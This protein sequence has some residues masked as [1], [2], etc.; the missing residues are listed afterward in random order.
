MADVIRG[1]QP[2]EL[3][4]TGFRAGPRA[5]EWFEALFRE[6]YPRI[7]ALVAR[8][9]GDRSQAEEIAA[10]SFSKL[11]ARGV[12]LASRQDVTAWVYRVATNAGLDAIRA[13]TRRRRK[14]EAASR[15]QLRTGEHTGALD[16]LLREERGAQ[17]RTI[18]AELKPRDAEILLLRSSG[19]AYREIA[20][21]LGIA[22]SSVG[23]M[24]ARAEREFE[25]RYRAR[26][27]DAI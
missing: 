27:G 19:L 8:L 7:V 25:R 1:V 20:E 11:A 14:E 9:T 22:A 5:G 16:E 12:L 18:L 10:E 6:H 13:N 4:V 26:Y 2:E 21:A 15:E 17:V 24:L 3:A 23:T